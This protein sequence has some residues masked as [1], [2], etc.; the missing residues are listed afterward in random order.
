M[1]GFRNFFFDDHQ[2][3]DEMLERAFILVLGNR[4]VLKGE[5]NCVVW[6]ERI[7]SVWT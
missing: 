1:I 5:I 7:A 4:L 6:V 3:F 2:V